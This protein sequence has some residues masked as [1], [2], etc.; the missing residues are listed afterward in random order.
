MGIFRE[1]FRQAS[2]ADLSARAKNDMA[3]QLE[4]AMQTDIIV[5]LLDE[6]LTPTGLKTLVKYYS[7]EKFMPPSLID[8]VAKK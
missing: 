8:E 2:Y 7:L 3:A 5:R 6:F 1:S 4:K